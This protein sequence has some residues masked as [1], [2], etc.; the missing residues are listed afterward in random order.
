MKAI[1]KKVIQSC[2][3]E[4]R[5]FT[6]KI[7]TFS[8]RRALGQQKLS[9]L[10]K[11]LERVV[12]DITDQFSRKRERSQFWKLKERGLHAFQCSL[13][14]NALESCP[15]K[16][17]TVVDIGD[18]AGTHMLYLRELGKKRFNIKSIS[19]NLDSRAVDK[20][21]ARGLEAKLCR[22]EEL[23]LGE[24]QIDLFTSFEMVEHLHNPAIFFRR[25]AGWP[26]ILRVTRC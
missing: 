22:A 13:M 14:L 2:G 18:S 9:N 8:I 23:D 19:V 25:S 21:R 17:L 20:I 5:T 16:D 15:G 12:P 3:L 4:P 6:E 1:L 7:D 11:E 26:R 10:V 24:S